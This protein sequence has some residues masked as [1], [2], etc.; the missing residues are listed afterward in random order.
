MMKTKGPSEETGA[1]YQYC[2]REGLTTDG[3]AII[4]DYNLAYMWYILGGIGLAF[5]II[6]AIAV[7]K[8]V[9]PKEI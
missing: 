6:G 9:W 2:T 7:S 8:I 5:T 1:D 3:N 4:Y